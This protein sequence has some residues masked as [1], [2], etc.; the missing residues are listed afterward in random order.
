MITRIINAIFYHGVLW[1][2]PWGL[3]EWHKKQLRKNSVNTT[4][5]YPPL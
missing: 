3:R 5:R 4:R 2:M 1:L